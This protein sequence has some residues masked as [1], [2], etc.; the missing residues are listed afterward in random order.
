MA[1]KRAVLVLAALV[2]GVALA[3]VVASMVNAQEIGPVPFVPNW[4][5]NASKYDHNGDGQ[6]TGA[7]FSLWVQAVHES[8][9]ACRLDGPSSG[10]PSWADVNGDGLVSHADLDAMFGYLFL[11]VY[12][13]GASAP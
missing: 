13:R 3:G 1:M 8:G 10:C 11:C 5:S 4:C 7:D 6:L 2:V 9:D 12:P